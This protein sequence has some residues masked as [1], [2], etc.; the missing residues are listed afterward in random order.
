[1][2]FNT[3]GLAAFTQKAT[4]MFAASVLY[5]EDY[6]VYDKVMGVPYK[7]AI[8]FRSKDG[9]YLQAGG[10]ELTASG[11]T[12]FT[13]KDLTATYFGSKEKY[14]IT[15]LRT[16]GLE[17]IDVI[18]ETVEQFNE[19]FGIEMDRL[20]WMGNT[21]SSD[22]MQGLVTLWEADSNVIDSG[23]ATGTTL[24]STNIDNA[25]ASVMA[26]IPVAL[27]KGGITIHVSYKTFNLYLEYLKTAIPGIIF[28]GANTTVN[29]S[30]EKL[31]VMV[32]GTNDV[33]LRVET[34]TNFPDDQMYATNDKNII[35]I[36]DEK[37]VISALDIVADPI[38]KNLFYLI[39]DFKFGVDY[40]FG[41]EVIK[42][43]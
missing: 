37:E 35:R 11:G 29:G 17:E 40:K 38:D 1:M 26:A 42:L 43:N 3:S 21:G 25:I 32:Y 2:S 16:F 23:F 9:L 39:T 30:M 20:F 8:K 34:A 31:E 24:T 19:S 7:K 13:S 36:Y 6:A 18:K 22:L 5:R 41:S 28:G 27:R 15:D 10:C 12:A 14:C 33:K 4:D